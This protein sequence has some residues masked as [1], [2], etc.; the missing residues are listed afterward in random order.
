MVHL[1]QGAGTAEFMVERWLTTVHPLPY[2]GYVAP[3]PVGDN[4]LDMDEQWDNWEEDQ[5]PGFQLNVHLV[6]IDHEILH[7]NLENFVFNDE[8]DEDCCWD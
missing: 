8:F 1:K 3:G 2:E 4:L 5:E 6:H 7:G